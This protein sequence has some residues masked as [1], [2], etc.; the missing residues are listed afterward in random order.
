MKK[1][2]YLLVLICILVGLYSSSGMTYEQQSLVP[3]LQE[4]LSG[5]PLEQTLSKLKIP[6]WGITVSVEER[7]YYYFVEFLLRKGAHFFIFG[8]L[9]SMIYLVL[10]KF[11]FRWITAA[12]LT[13][14]VAIVDEYHQSLTGGRTATLQ[15]VAL[16]MAGALT[17]LI[18]FR[19]CLLFGKRKKIR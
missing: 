8:L 11:T 18:I 16:D 9:A 17:F 6:Y 10:P 13:L 15:D 5:K 19:V 7:G 1:L 4:K 3:Q 2:I 12:G 14:F